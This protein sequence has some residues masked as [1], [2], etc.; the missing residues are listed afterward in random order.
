MRLLTEE[1]D[2]ILQARNNAIRDANDAFDDLE[3]RLDDLADDIIESQEIE[4]EKITS[5]IDRAVI[6]R[7][8][9]L[10]VFFAL[11][12]EWLTSTIEIDVSVPAT[13]T[14]T[15]TREADTFDKYDTIFD[16]FHYD[17]GHGKG[18]G[19]GQVD[20]APVTDGPWTQRA[21]PSGPVGDYEQDVGQYA[22]AWEMPGSK[23][24]R[25]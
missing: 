11:K 18:T 3:W 13:P 6:D 8:P 2:D 14:A 4:I 9:A 17:I 19:E 10:N 7:K 5:A 20:D 16:D 1:E 12:V 15:Y 25:Y 24:M 21:G 23:A 22:H